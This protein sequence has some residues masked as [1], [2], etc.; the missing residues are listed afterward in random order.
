MS[1][2][3]IFMWWKIGLSRFGGKLMWWMSRVYWPNISISCGKKCRSIL[4]QC[5]TQCWRRLRPP[6]WA[7]TRDKNPLSYLELFMVHS[8]LL[9]KPN[10]SL[11]SNARVAWSNWISSI[12]YKDQNYDSGFKKKYPVFLMPNHSLQSSSKFLLFPSQM[13]AENNHLQGT[14]LEKCLIPLIL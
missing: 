4:G 3:L 7:P 11:Q 5:D 14:S 12:K 10:C 6:S 1:L 13:L 8:Y 9:A 2:T